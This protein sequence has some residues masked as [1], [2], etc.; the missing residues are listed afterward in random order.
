MTELSYQ[1]LA[2]D[3]AEQKVCEG[4]WGSRLR[5]PARPRRRVTLLGARGG[6]CG[7]AEWSEVDK[8]LNRMC[9]VCVSRE[10]TEINDILHGIFRH[11]LTPY[12]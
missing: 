7:K 8:G 1:Y 5:I 2:F 4:L 11:S 12:S 6:N 9:S 3:T 10:V